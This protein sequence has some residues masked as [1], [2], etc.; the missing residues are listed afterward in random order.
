[1]VQAT[2]QARVPRWGAWVGAAR[3]GGLWVVVHVNLLQAFVL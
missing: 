1:M 3:A 2:R